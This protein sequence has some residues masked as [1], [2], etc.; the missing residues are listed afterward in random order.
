MK[1]SQQIVLFVEN[2]TQCIKN[3]KLSLIGIVSTN[4]LLFVLGT[5]FDFDVMV[6]IGTTSLSSL[7]AL[8]GAFSIIKKIINFKHELN[9]LNILLIKA[10]ELEGNPKSYTASEIHE[11]DNLISLYYKKA[12][13]IIELQE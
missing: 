7:A 8:A 10:L 13:G 5:S 1:R 2:L 6:K 12:L 11:L 3:Y 4:V 9:T